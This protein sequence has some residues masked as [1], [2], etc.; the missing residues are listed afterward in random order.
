MYVSCLETNRLFIYQNF[1]SKNDH[2]SINVITTKN[3]IHHIVGVQ[4]FFLCN[5]LKIVASSQVAESSRF[6]IHA[7]NDFSIFITNGNTANVVIN[8][9]KE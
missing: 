1:F 5:S 6:I 4:F 8:A 3:T 2:N 7:F 9:N